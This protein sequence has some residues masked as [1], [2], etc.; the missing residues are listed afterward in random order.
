MGRETAA[1]FETYDRSHAGALGM[2]ELRQCLADLGTLVRLEGVLCVGCRLK[3]LHVHCCCADGASLDCSVIEAEAVQPR[4][5]R[6]PSTL[7][8]LAL[9]WVVSILCNGQRRA[10]DTIA[11]ACWFN[12]PG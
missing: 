4:S 11:G 8:A 3:D 9:S 10:A 12:C 6:G 5:V 2:E 1:I 7:K